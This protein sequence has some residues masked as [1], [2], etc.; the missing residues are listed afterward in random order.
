MFENIE[1]LFGKLRDFSVYSRDLVTLSTAIGTLVIVYYSVVTAATLFRGFHLYILNQLSCCKSDFRKKYGQWA[2]V[3]GSTDGIG[4]A[5]AKELAR[6]GHSVIVIGRNQDKL[7]RTEEEL[8]KE[9]NVGEV[10]TVK[11]DLSDSS[12]ENY[13]R[14]EEIIDPSHRDIGI[15]INNAGTFNSIYKRF[16]NSDEDYLR[17]MVNVNILATVNFTR[18]IMPSMIARG[19]GLVINV[20]SMIGRLP[21]PYMGIYGPTK[22]FIN[23]FSHNLQTEYSQHPIDIINLE[24]GPV[25]TKLFDDAAELGKSS[26]MVPTS[27]EYARSAL[28]AASSPVKSMTGIMSHGI[29]MHISLF[30]KSIGILTPLLKLNMKFTAKNVQLSPVPKRKQLASSVPTNEAGDQ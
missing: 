30:M 19:K 16:N 1:E 3:T 9:P 26:K 5:M 23:H 2:V 27:E 11:I 18:M 15:L 7:N 29:I 14:V 4:L 20:S 24:T 22:S 17:G 12:L 8:L 13:K 6:K 28:N 25:H 21:V 10:M